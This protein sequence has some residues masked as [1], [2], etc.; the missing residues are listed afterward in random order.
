MVKD[1]VRIEYDIIQGQLLR[2]TNY[3][4]IVAYTLVFAM[5]HVR[6]KLHC[7]TLFVFINKM[8]LNT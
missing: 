7:C 2:Y 1:M 4:E 8:V 3:R 6:C 5:Q